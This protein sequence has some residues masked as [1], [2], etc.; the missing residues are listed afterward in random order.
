VGGVGELAAFE[1]GVRVPAP[2]QLTTI[3]QTY[4][5]PYEHLAP[6]FYRQEQTAALSLLTGRPPSATTPAPV[7]TT[8]TDASYQLV[9]NLYSF[10]AAA[11][12]NDTPLREDTEAELPMVVN[13]WPVSTIPPYLALVTST[14]ADA[15]DQTDA[16]RAS[17]DSDDSAAKP[18]STPQVTP[19]SGSVVSGPGS[20]TTSRPAGRAAGA[21]RTSV[22]KDSTGRTVTVTVTDEHGETATLAA[23]V[24]KVRARVALYIITRDI[25]ALAGRMVPGPTYGGRKYPDMTVTVH[26]FR[27]LMANL[28]AGYT[29]RDLNM[30]RNQDLSTFSFADGLDDYFQ[31][32]GM[33]PFFKNP[34]PPANTQR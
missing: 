26:M 3:A 5:R 24:E 19:V 8:T 14:T 33:I 13:G 2:S 4:G 18:G 10:G 6:L 27:Q 7:T 12:D 28:P 9:P 11:N 25:G 31:Q 21:L 16:I 23:A 1:A 22:T 30:I 17:G 32:L 20:S 29:S 34:D 15:T